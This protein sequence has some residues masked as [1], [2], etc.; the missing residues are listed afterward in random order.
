[1][2][3]SG[4]SQ[5]SAVKWDKINDN[6]LKYPE[7][8]SLPGKL[9]SPSNRLFHKFIF[10]LFGREGGSYKLYERECKDGIFKTFYDLLTIFVE[11]WA[12]VTLPQRE[13]K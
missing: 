7:F 4:S 11:L 13:E 3:K 12:T 8:T 5:N 6:E 1:M 10:S 2:L 9:K